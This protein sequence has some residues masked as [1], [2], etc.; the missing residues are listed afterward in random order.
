MTAA[1]NSDALLR[2]PAVR[3]KLGLSRSSIYR[4]VAAGQLPKPVKLSAQS[5]AWRASELD[6]W[7]AKL[8]P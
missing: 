4:L 1:T 2:L 8:N 7:I 3:A 6:A 5:I